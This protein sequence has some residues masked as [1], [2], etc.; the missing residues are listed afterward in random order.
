MKMY[1]KNGKKIIE[2]GNVNDATI[3]ATL[4]ANGFIA[5]S[6][7]DL[8]TTPDFIIKCDSGVYPGI[9]NFEQYVCDKAYKWLME[10]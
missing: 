8:F 6:K 7:E 10:D 9:I 2:V 1:E 4:T 3:Y 5:V